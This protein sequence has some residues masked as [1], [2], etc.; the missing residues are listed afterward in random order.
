MK[1]KSADNPLAIRAYLL[2]LTHYDPW[3]WKRKKREKPFD[4]ELGLEVVDHLADAGFNTLIIDVKDGV[5][6]KS[7][8]RISRH[9]TQ[10]MSVLKR[11][12]AKAESR[13]LEVVPK[14]NFSQSPLHHHNDWFYPYNRLFDNWEYWDR[15]GK[16]MD[17]LIA[18][19][20]PKRFFHVGMDE[21]HS[22]AYSQY[23]TAIKHMHKMLKQRGL[24]TVIWNDTAAFE[25]GG[26]NVVHAEKS[27][28]AETRI[29]KDIVQVLWNYGGVTDKQIKRL[30]KLGFEV[31]VAPGWEP[32]LVEG[33]R[34]LVLKHK[35]KGMVMTFWVPC[36][37]YN[38]ARM[39][40]LIKGLGPLYSRGVP[41]VKHAAR[42]A[43]ALDLYRLRRKSRRKA[44][45]DPWQE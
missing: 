15:A 28:Y 31:W 22:R 6:F 44:K 9:Y 27:E 36:R 20:K 17:E 8:P 16:L 25:W 12:V 2:H 37:P 26:S 32:K 10:P 43:P 33:W 34:E 19:C 4:L 29:P 21:D 38:G 23:V 40:K 42:P 35:G 11:L 30:R 45:R 5:R 7:L 41:G 13:G 18:V 1:K 14:L 3:W 39:K 24:R